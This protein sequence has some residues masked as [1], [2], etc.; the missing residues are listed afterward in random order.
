V[1]EGAHTCAMDAPVLVPAQML[2]ALD[3]CLGALRRERVIDEL[4]EWR[5]I[6]GEVIGRTFRVG[7]LPVSVSATAARTQASRHPGSC[8]PS[9][10]E[11]MGA[12]AMT[13]FGRDCGMACRDVIGSD[14]AF[15]VHRLA[16]ALAVLT[17]I[18]EPTLIS[19]MLCHRRASGI[20]IPRALGQVRH[21]GG[22]VWGETLIDVLFGDGS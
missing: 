5:R 14:D 21:V 17:G 3:A 22:A 9:A 10:C 19:S 6:D 20:R 8:R 1:G 12:R 18:A 7:S 15:V 2:A 11:G 16:P 13:L 4:E